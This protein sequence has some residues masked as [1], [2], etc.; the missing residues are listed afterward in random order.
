MTLNNVSYNKN[1][2]TLINK[3]RNYYDDLEYC[4]AKIWLYRDVNFY[5]KRRK[6]D[7]KIIPSEY[8]AARRTLDRYSIFPKE[9]SFSDIIRHN[10]IGTLYE[11]SSK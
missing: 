6:Y 3:S 10:T 9:Q 2:G 4:C 11:R 1:N 5:I 7:F 8:I